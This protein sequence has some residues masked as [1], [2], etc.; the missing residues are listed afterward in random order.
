MGISEAPAR[1]GEGL[2]RCAENLNTDKLADVL[3][4][5]A[6]TITKPTWSR[7]LLSGTTIGHPT[8]PML[9]DVPIGAWMAASVLDA[10]GGPGAQPA[11]R[12][13]IGVGVAAAIPTALSGLN[14]WGDTYGPETRIGLA[15][16]A[17]VHGALALYGASYLARRRGRT[18]LGKLIGFAGFGT[19]LGAA[20]LGGHLSFRRAMVVNHTAFEERPGDWTDVAAAAD[21]DE[22]PTL[23]VTAGSAPVLLHK[24]NDRIFAMSNTCSHMG[25]PLDEGTFADGCVTCQ[26]HGSVFRLEDGS[27]VRGPATTPQPTY[28]VRVTAGRIEVKARG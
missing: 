18:K 10:V 24:I 27:I 6:H 14:D 12:K 4:K 9:T 23:R 28:D 2:V 1:L 19:L 25:G 5:V 13:L 7:N 8:H 16:A 17:G 20:Y 22:T 15:H 11:V 26:W 21:L 3:M